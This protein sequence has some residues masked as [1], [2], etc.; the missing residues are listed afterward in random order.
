MNQEMHQRHAENESSSYGFFQ[1][2]ERDRGLISYE[3]EALNV[4]ITQIVM[5]KRAELQRPVR[6][7]DIGCGKGGMIRGL[8]EKFGVD[9]QAWGMDL[10][11]YN[12]RNEIP[13]V[14]ASIEKGISP[15]AFG[16]EFD[17]IF[18]AFV[19]MYIRDKMRALLNTAK[20][21]ADNGRAYIHLHSFLISTDHEPVFLKEYDTHAE[22]QRFQHVLDRIIPG[23]RQLL[24][25]VEGSK[26]ATTSMFDPSYFIIEK[27]AENCKMPRYIKS[28]EAP[29]SDRFCYS[30]YSMQCVS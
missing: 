18:S 30:Q 21:L 15:D 27:G 1:R 16:G 11:D 26:S 22:R 20:L 29:W 8:Q 13:F 28:I 25:Y 24:R 3:I 12:D 5:Q 23:Q 14:Q 17:L 6:V 4:N 7:L 19:Y 2:K 9:V 10:H